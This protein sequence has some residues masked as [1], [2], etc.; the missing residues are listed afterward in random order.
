MLVY[1]RK[2]A[3]ELLNSNVVIKK[4]FLQQDFDDKTINSLLQNKK[5]PIVYKTKKELDKLAETSHQGIMLDIEDYK[6]YNLSSLLEK[7]DN[8]FLVLLDHLEDPHNLGAIIRTC[9]AA[10]VNGII[11]PKDRGVKITSTV[12]KTSAGALTNMDLCL[13]SNVAQTIKKLRQEGYW[14]VGTDMQGQDYRTIDYNGK[15]VLIIGNE[16]HGMS[17]IVK[18]SCDF[19][20]SIPMKGKINSLNA[21]VASGIMIYEVIRNRK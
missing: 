4:I 21:S 3:V 17:R 8:S 10:G 2:V 11:L 20:A 18:E 7:E 6:Y 16:G 1:G 15:I 12:M 14:I 5:I 9:E 13:V 19:V